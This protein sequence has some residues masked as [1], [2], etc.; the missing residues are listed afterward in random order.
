MEENNRE[1]D[2]IVKHYFKAHG[3]TTDE[4]GS[5]PVPK[6]Q[7]ASEYVREFVKEKRFLPNSKVLREDILHELYEKLVHPEHHARKQR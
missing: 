6:E 3:E 5:N 7:Q 4:I 1:D 2:V